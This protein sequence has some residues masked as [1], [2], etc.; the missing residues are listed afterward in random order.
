[1]VENMTTLPHLII[2]HSVIES[3]LK[4]LQEAGNERKERVL[5]WLAARHPQELIIQEVYLPRQQC[6]LDSFWIPREGMEELHVH[7]RKHSLMVAA[8]IHSHPFEAFHSLADNRW[9]I[10][11]HVG[12]LSLVLPHFALHSKIDSFDRDVAIYRLSSDNQWIEVLQ[13]E[14][15]RCYRIVS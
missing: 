13:K 15:Y 4:L 8:Q 12:A 1:M 5:L 11:R 7:L 2:P 14:H 3:S 9:A 10:I 6:E